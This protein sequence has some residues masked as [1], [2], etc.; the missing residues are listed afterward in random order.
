MSPTPNPNSD[1]VSPTL[2]NDREKTGEN[3]KTGCR[4]GSKFCRNGEGR[5][6][7]ISKLVDRFHF[8]RLSTVILAKQR[9]LVHLLK[10]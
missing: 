4:H 5:K 10:I 1:P 6:K 7:H 8:S 2:S 3:M 9:F